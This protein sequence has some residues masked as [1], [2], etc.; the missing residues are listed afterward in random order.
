VTK[1]ED[2]KRRVRGNYDTYNNVTHL[3]FEV[4]LRKGLD[5]ERIQ[6]H[7]EGHSQGTVVMVDLSGHR[8]KS[9]V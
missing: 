1:G 8:K 6:T 2:K 4:L 3:E 5:M 7:K 9:I